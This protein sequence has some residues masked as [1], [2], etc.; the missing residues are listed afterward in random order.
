MK[1]IKL[2]TAMALLLL[3]FKPKASAQFYFF[4]KDH[5]DTHLL[6]EAGGSFGVMNCLSDIGGR[7]GRG[8][9]FIKDLNIG[10]THINGG[11]YLN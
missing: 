11:F 3:A 5:Y 8:K 7:K 6:F 9:P 4:D 2:I 10:N 1:K